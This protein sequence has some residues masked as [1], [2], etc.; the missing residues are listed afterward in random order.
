MSITKPATVGPLATTPRVVIFVHLFVVFEWGFFFL[1][2]PWLFTK[3]YLVIFRWLD[4]YLCVWH[5]SILLVITYFTVL[6]DSHDQRL[7]RGQWDIYR[8]SKKTSL[9]LSMQHTCPSSC[10]FLTGLEQPPP[11]SVG[12]M[13]RGPVRKDWNKNPVF[14]RDNAYI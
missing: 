5:F 13:G 11:E 12:S 1:C 10:L 14:S 3:K 2:W 4:F 9:Q 8:H 7:V 6:L